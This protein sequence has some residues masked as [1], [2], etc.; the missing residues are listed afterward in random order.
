VELANDPLPEMFSK[1]GGWHATGVLGKSS[2]EEM[3]SKKHP[4]KGGGS[5]EKQRKESLQ[6]L[7]KMRKTPRWFL[8]LWKGGGVDLPAL[9]HKTDRGTQVKR[10]PHKIIPKDRLKTASIIGGQIHKA[11]NLTTHVGG[12]K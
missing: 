1:G 4:Q 10:V 9:K 2:R 11:K 7:W 8:R 5:L 6:H 12:P 3:A